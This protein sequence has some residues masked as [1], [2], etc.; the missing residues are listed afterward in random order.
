MSRCSA[1]AALLLLAG[2][3]LS[4][5]EPYVE[6]PDPPAD[7]GIYGFANG[8]YAVD[9]TAP[10]SDNTRWLVADGERFSFSAL[11]LEDGARFVLRPS[12]LGTYLLYDEGE[13]YLVS[14]DGALLRQDE[15][16]SDILLIDDTYR[17]PAEWNIEVAA[18]RSRRASQLRHHADRRATSRSRRLERRRRETPR[19]WRSIPPRAARTFPELTLDAEGSV[20]PR[21][22]PDGDLFGIVETHSHLFTNFGFGGGGMFHGSPFHRSASSTRCPSCEPFHGVE[23]RATSSASAF[24]GLVGRSIRRAAHR[25]RHRAHAR[26][27]PPHRGLPRVHRLAQRVEQRHAPDAVLPLARARAPRGPAPA[28]AARDDQLACSAR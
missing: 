12:D 3:V 10:G 16:L 22:W 17:S 25:V 19:S 9:A 8:C 23:G 4:G 13:H 14:E 18:S 5:C 2:L 1:L 7:D 28:R 20:E 6:R 27:Q 24:S 11:A 15:L 26:A 21:A